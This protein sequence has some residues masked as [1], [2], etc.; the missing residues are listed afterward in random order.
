MLRMRS[1]NLCMVPESK[2]ATARNRRASLFQRWQER[3]R[4]AFASA[5]LTSPHQR[6]ID[7]LWTRQFTY[8]FTSTERF[9]SIRAAMAMV[10]LSSLT[11]ATRT[12]T[13]MAMSTTIKTLRPTT[14]WPPLSTTRTVVFSPNSSSN[15]AR[16]GAA[17]PILK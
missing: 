17:E 6:F 1:S 16:P 8:A 10:P 4:A 5:R 12:T 3:A 11:R 14:L 7:E 15:G 13:T 2:L 9:S